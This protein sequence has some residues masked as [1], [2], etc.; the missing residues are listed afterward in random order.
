MKLNINKYGKAFT[1]KNIC[2]TNLTRKFVNKTIVDKL[3]DQNNIKDTYFINKRE[4][5]MKKGETKKSYYERY[6]KEPTQNIRI[7]NGMP[8]IASKT[9]NQGDICVNN[10]EFIITKIDDKELE[11]VSQRPDG[12]HSITIPTKDFYAYF[13]VAYC[14]TTH[15]AQGSTIKDK[16]TIWDWDIMDEKLRYTA[17]TR[18]TKNKDINFVKTP[19]YKTMINSI[20]DL[21]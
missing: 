12:S 3:I 16:I 4:I 10:E 18:A 1:K 20:D 7:F 2:Y 14:I 8:I 13:L 9:H 17:L 15:K 5:K 11:A 6:S 21:L 19:A